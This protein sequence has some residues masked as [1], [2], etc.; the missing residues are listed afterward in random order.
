M[1][2]LVL[3]ALLIGVLAQAS[4]ACAGDMVETASREWALLAGYGITHRGFGATQTQVQTADLI[5]R[6]GW[7]LS[8]EVGRGWYRGRHQLL[9]ELPLHVAVDQRERVM[10]GGYVL[11]SWKFTGLAA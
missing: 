4:P 7:F 11:G 3:V 5:G 1:K 6:F 8:D 10:T 9:L 2:R